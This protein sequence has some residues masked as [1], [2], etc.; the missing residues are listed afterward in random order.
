LNPYY[1]YY[2]NTIIINKNFN[3]GEY[4]QKNN[5]KGSKISINNE[6][7]TELINYDK[8]RKLTTISVIKNVS[9]LR[10]LLCRKRN[11]TK[12]FY[13]KAKFVIS[14]YLS[15][16]DLFSHLVEYYRLKKLILSD[17]EMNTLNS[18]RQ[19]LVLPDEL[20]K[21]DLDLKVLISNNI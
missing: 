21:E 9:I 7:S 12:E 18:M 16:E 14:K 20:K 10:Y 3:Y 1:T 11:K 8:S 4:R 2:K 17:K 5:T 6:I 15:I 13:E 19:R